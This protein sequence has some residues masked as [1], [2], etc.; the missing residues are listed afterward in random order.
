MHKIECILEQDN[1]SLTK[2]THSMQTILART[3]F[4]RSGKFVRARLRLPAEN[5]KQTCST[6]SLP[7]HIRAFVTSC[8]TWLIASA[9]RCGSEGHK[10]VT[11]CQGEGELGALISQTTMT[12]DIR[13]GLGIGLT[14]PVHEPLYTLYGLAETPVRL[15][16]ATHALT[17]CLLIPT[18]K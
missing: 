4:R 16:T 3:R 9:L 11:H 18:R 12:N 6:P 17:C 5:A 14:R 1:D 13:R 10:G 7:K 2:H 8:S 15:P